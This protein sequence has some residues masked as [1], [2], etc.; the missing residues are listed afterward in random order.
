MTLLLAAVPGLLTILIYLVIIGIVLA[1]AYYVINNLFPEPFRRWA[2]VIL[3]V[4]GAVLLIWL[5]LQLVGGGPSF[6]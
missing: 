2:T 5:L 6:W 3:V 1:V 4:V